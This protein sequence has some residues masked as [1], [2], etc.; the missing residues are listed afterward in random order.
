MEIFSLLSR[1]LFLNQIM[2]IGIL[3][4]ET[5]NLITHIKNNLLIPPN[6]LKT[7]NFSKQHAN[8]DQSQFGQDHMVAKLLNFKRNGIFIEAGAYDGEIHSNTL[9][10]ELKYN[11]TGILVEPNPDSF[12]EL[13]TKHRNCYAINTCLSTSNQVEDVI[14]DAAG[15]K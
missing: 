15:I 7:Y 10:L 3:A 9:Q 8:N 4:D 13:L 6:A 12:Q 14:F 2:N 5:K 11:W 1:I